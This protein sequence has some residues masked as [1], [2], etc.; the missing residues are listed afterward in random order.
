MN[1][2]EK[3]DYFQISYT[4]D[5]RINWKHIFDKDLS[6]NLEIG[7][8]RGDFLIEKSRK[9]PN[10]NFLGIEMKEKRIKT[11]IKK[12]DKNQNPNVRILQMFLN[13]KNMGIFPHCSFKKIYIKHPDPWPKRR[14][15]KRR[16]IQKGV[17]DRLNHIL[18]LNGKIEISTD[19]ADYAKWI[20]RIF[21]KRN[22]FYPLF[23][24]GYQR[25]EPEGNIRT[26]F[27]RKKR[28]KGLKPYFMCYQKREEIG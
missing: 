7:S 1:F 11:I 10:V 2:A 27:E 5:K 4:E 25:Q 16:L 23:Q 8:G 21:N 14:H 12:L 26:Y 24:D 6:L 13:E 20:V 9:E 18:Q 19:H 22:D 28:K 15:H 3:R 17:V